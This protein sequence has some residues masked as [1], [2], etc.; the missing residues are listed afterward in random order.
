[1]SRGGEHSH[2][3]ADLGDDPLGGEGGHARDGGQQGA[4]AGQVTGEVTG[5]D[6]SGTTGDVEQVAAANPITIGA[7]PA[8]SSAAIVLLAVIMLVGVIVVPPLVFGVL[9]SKEGTK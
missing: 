1:M 5:G 9:R 7:D 8:S 6:G 3:S 4:F 2:V